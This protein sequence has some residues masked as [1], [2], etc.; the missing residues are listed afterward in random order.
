MY[1]EIYFTNIRNMPDYFYYNVGWDEMI[2]IDGEHAMI[3]GGSVV[4]YIKK[5]NGTWVIHR[6]GGLPARV[7]SGYYKRVNFF[8]N[9]KTLRIEDLS[10]SDEEKVLLL[11]KYEYDI[12]DDYHCYV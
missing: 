11:L 7:C 5:C 2:M 4:T 1:K 8:E 10:I 6:A 3:V 12:N 9:G